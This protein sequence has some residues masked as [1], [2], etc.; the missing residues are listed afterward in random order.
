[1]QERIMTQRAGPIIETSRPGF[2]AVKLT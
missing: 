1:M 2:D